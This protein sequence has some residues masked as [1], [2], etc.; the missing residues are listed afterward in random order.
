VG[1]GAPSRRATIFALMLP[2]MVGTLRLAH[3]TLAA[4]AETRPLRGKRVHAA[5]NWS[6]NTSFARPSAGI[7]RR[8][9]SPP[10]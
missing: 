7:P 9:M 5:S 10:P 4:V 2:R 3:P 1:K 8:A 6:A